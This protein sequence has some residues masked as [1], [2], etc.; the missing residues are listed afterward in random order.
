VNPTVLVLDE[1]TAALDPVAERHA[2]AGYEQLMR[3]RTT[4]LITH[5]MALAAAADRVL[6]LGGTGSS[7][8]DGRWSCRRAAARMRRCLRRNR[9]DRRRRGAGF[10]CDLCA[11]CGYRGLSCT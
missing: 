9:G 4:L 1:P 8:R 11:L 5:R 2:R 10:L 7:N 3:G 6:V